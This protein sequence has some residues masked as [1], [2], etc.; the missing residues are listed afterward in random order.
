MI[1]AFGNSCLHSSPSH[2]SPQLVY[3]FISLRNIAGNTNQISDS[4][5]AEVTQLSN[6]LFY[7]LLFVKLHRH[8][9]TMLFSVICFFL[10]YTFAAVV[11]YNFS[12]SARGFVTQRDQ[13]AFTDIS[14]WSEY[15]YAFHSPHSLSLLSSLNLFT[16][17]LFHFFST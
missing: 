17:S 9:V 7:L 6:F 16:P 15:K 10:V 3:P 5:L 13:V 14:A 8:Q 1:Q 12:R 4:F 11:I 2:L